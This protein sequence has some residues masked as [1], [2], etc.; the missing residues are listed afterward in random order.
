[1]PSLYV[2]HLMG[3]A[4]LDLA[5]IEGSEG[6]FRDQDPLAAKRGDAHNDGVVGDHDTAERASPTVR[7]SLERSRT[8]PRNSHSTD[9]A[10]T[11]PG[12][13]SAAWVRGWPE[14]PRWIATS[15]RASSQHACATAL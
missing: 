9:P 5:G 8:H 12:S 6:R 3:Q 1:M 2:T 7:R 13:T 15:G 14:R 11:R 4:G 10:T